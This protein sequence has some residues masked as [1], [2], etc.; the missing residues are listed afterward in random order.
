LSKL[1]WQALKELEAKL[2]VLKIRLKAELGVFN[3]L[4]DTY[5]VAEIDASWNRLAELY[6]GKYGEGFVELSN[7]VKSLREILEKQKPKE[8]GKG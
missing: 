4:L 8:G 1:Y 3:A 5:N 7:M 6:R 2:P